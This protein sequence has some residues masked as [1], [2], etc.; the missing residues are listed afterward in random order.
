MLKKVNIENY[1]GVS[2]T[3][4]ERILPLRK[5]YWI[6]LDFFPGGDAPKNFIA[7]YQ[8]ERDSKIKRWNS[9]TWPRYIAKVGHKW[10]PMESINEYLFNQIGEVLGLKMASSQLAY[11][12]KQLRFLSRYFLEKNESLDHG[13]Q[14]FA[15]Y[16]NDKHFVENVEEQGL[17]RKFFTFQFAEN[18]I[19]QMFPH[20]AE[21]ILE[22][23]VQMLVFDA[24]TGNNDRHFYNWGVI[25]HIE[26]KKK[27][28][29][30]PIF[31][32]AR[33]LFWNE[34]ETKLQKLYEQP[35]Q[36]DG[37][38]K[39]YS[40]GSRP[41]IGWEGLD[42]LNHFDLINQLFFRDLR[43]KK[44]CIDLINQENLTKVLNLVDKS[45]AKFYSNKR[46]ELIKKCLI[47]RFERL[48]ILINIKG[49]VT[50]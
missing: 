1:S 9:D 5:G 36:I 40:E 10:Y 34:S 3:L 14:I 15:G 27:P 25:K 39:K 44:V 49:V 31:D 42:D 24:I 32:S 17:A 4:N 35:K 43:Y 16:M 11:T 46:A 8:Y 6:E 33:G 47:Y 28:T 23:F 21:S 26:N 13:A 7:I 50:C 22:S 38:I 19:R 18:A 29:F 30:A 37:R 20:E 12:G 48:M 45:F 2:L 41:K